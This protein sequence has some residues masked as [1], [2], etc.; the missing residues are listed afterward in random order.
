MLLAAALPL[1]ASGCRGCNTPER[2]VV[3]YTSVDRSFSEPVF[4]DFEKTAD[5]R[6]KAVYD[7]PGTTP[8]VFA[9]LQAEEKAPQA[10]VFWSGDPIRP[11]S[12]I[13]KGMVDAYAS[14]HASAIPSSWRAP[15][16]AWTG[17]AA[18][19]RVLIVNRNRVP[20]DRTPRSIRAMIDPAW[21]GQSAIADP[22]HGTTTMQ[23]AAWFAAWGDDKARGFLDA[24]KGNAVRVVASNEEVAR[25]VVA[26][27]IAFGLADTDDAYVAMQEAAHVAVVYPDQDSEG[28]LVMPTSAV[29][30]R[31]GPHPDTARALMDHLVSR[32]VE[33]HLAENAAHIPLRAGI[34]VPPTLKPVT[35]I[36]AMSVD[37]GKLAQE[38]DRIRP[39]LKGWVGS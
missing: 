38:M 19:A 14:P 3:V 36:R 20:A 6:V 39:W 31:N 16:G 12:L 17:F 1:A 18:R 4:R 23:V 11:F 5:V 13:R 32:E 24:L 22:L 26:G 29:V 9:R 15:D 34:P 8:D 37:Y 21:K 7:E 30:V 28:T 33:Q 10:D 2:E 27:E 35:Q 25:L